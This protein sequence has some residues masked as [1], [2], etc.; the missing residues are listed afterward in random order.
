MHGG[1]NG[2]GAP[3]G[4]ANGMYRHGRY[5]KKHLEEIRRSRAILGAARSFLIKM[6][7]L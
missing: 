1:A 4:P 3:E 7:G 2:I 5:T 6:E